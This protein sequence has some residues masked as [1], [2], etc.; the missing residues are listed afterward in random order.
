QARLT[1]LAMVLRLTELTELPI[2]PLSDAIFMLRPLVSG[3]T[4]SKSRPSIVFVVTTFAPAN[5]RR[6]FYFRASSN[7]ILPERWLLSTCSSR[8]CRNIARFGITDRRLDQHSSFV[9]LCRPSP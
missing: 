6:G 3:V 2:T 9:S 8:R 7:K 5:E 4:G 1:P